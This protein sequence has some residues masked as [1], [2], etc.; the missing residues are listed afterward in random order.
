VKIQ[1]SAN[2][3]ASTWVTIGSFDGVHL[4]HQ[5]ILNVLSSKSQNRKT[6]AVAVSFFPHPA[7]VLGNITHPFYL[8]S[9]DEKNAL[10]EKYGA[11]EI[12]T[13]TFDKTFSRLSPRDF[14]RLLREKVLFSRLLI[15]YDFRLG[16]DRAG[17]HQSLDK[18]GNEMGF[19]VEVINPVLYG[20]EPIS[21]SRIRKA[22]NE[23]NLEQA[24][25]ML[26]YSY[27]VAGKVVHGDGRGKH[28]GLPT[29][30]VQP[31]IQ[32]LIPAPGVYAAFTEVD[33]NQYPSVVNVG[34][35]PTFYEEGA[36]QTIETHIM[37]FS[38]EIYGKKIK[39]HFIE[40]LRPE[41]K[42]DDVDPLMA[43]IKYDIINAKEIL[44]DA[45]KPPNLPA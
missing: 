12:F 43:Q 40:R 14:I 11:N 23:A 24:N 4:G 10:L 44:S 29:A 38:K 8:S 20:D 32:K 22:I 7:V 27:F 9:L 30:N 26:G 16:A 5:K 3:E 13:F 2:N 21:S 42:F 36:L 1:A 35:R 31:W 33:K 17:D 45:T 28:I 34:H 25:A 37:D 15:G 39:I 6:T 19:S 18:L 41:I